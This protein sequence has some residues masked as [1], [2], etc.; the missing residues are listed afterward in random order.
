MKRVNSNTDQRPVTFSDLGPVSRPG[1][2]SGPES[3]L[4]FAPFELDS[5]RKFSSIILKMIH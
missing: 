3:C 1:K 5:R 4:M 2:F